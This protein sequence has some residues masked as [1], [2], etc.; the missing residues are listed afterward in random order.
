MSVPTSTAGE[1]G[2]GFGP[3]WVRAQ[4]EGKILG[5]HFVNRLAEAL[6]CAVLAGPGSTAM[7]RTQNSSVHLYWWVYLSHEGQKDTQVGGPVAGFHTHTNIKIFVRKAWTSSHI[8]PHFPSMTSIYF[9]ISIAT[10]AL[11]LPQT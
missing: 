8:C 5:C 7:L 11:K 10:A 2:V 4:V 3:L 9:G 6:W 1:L